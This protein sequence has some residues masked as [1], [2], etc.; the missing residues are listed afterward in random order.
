MA[1]IYN[2]EYNEYKAL[3]DFL[4]KF[5]GLVKHATLARKN[6][7]E[8]II[9]SNEQGHNLAHVHVRKQSYEI[10]IDLS[11]CKL[12]EQSKGFSPKEVK[13]ARTFVKENRVMFFNHWNEFTNGVR[14][15]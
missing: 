10:V 11:T 3:C 5:N 15:Y 12:L 9:H 7:L 4:I 1:H 8:F 14:V 6:G 2:S 13:Q